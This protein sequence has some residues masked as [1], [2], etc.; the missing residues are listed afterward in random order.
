L[1]TQRNDSQYLRIEYRSEPNKRRDA[2]SEVWEDCKHEAPI[3]FRDELPPWHI[4]K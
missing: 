2:K 4:N 1:I 3:L